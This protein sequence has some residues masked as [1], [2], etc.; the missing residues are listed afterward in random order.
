MRADPIDALASTFPSGAYVPVI[1]APAL[2]SDL[3][4]QS[5]IVIDIRDAD[6]AQVAARKHDVRVRWWLELG[7]QLLLVGDRGEVRKAAP[8][9]EVLGE[10]V[11]LDRERLRL[12]AIGCVREA[13]TPGRLIAHGGRWE[14]RELS[15]AEL[16][17][18][19]P[20]LHDGH[21]DEWR[22]IE[23][24]SVI[25][26]RYRPDGGPAPADPRIQPV[27][28]SINTVRWFADLATLADWD[29][30]S[31]GPELAQS[32]AWIETQFNGLGL[33]VTAPAFTMPGSGG[34]QISVNNVIGKWTG[35]LHPDEWIVVGGHYDS[36]NSSL[37]SIVNTPG[38]EDNAS[39]CAGVI[40]LARALVP[41]QPERSILF[42]CYAGEEQGLY[43]S[44]AHVQ[45]LQASGDLAK[46]QA[47]ITMDMIGYS[48]DSQLD[49]LFESSATWTAYLNQFAAAAA[50]YVPDLHVS[51]STN[52]FGSDHIPYL[53]AG[54]RTLLAIEYDYDDYPYYHRSTD[55]PDHVGPNAQAMGG[56]ILKTSAAVL[57]ELAGVNDRIFVDGFESSGP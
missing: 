45:A 28:D 34:G 51:L 14:L 10:I 20:S 12:H 19:L 25:A 41:V 21:S 15:T 47:V 22:A 39:G 1:T 40:E 29:R 30:S 13:H 42:M 17:T 5:A 26:Q 27:V 43:G 52:P 38:A 24:D 37:S 23:P 53:N 44:K 31:Y 50:T 54:K 48:A 35:S 55:T 33:A 8:E 3:A 11:D 56:A 46:V 18:P 9:R 16:A 7:D 32:R 49:V 2:P 6:A 4:Q 36:R 57:A